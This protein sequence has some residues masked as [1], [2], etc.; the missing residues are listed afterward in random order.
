MPRLMLLNDPPTDNM[1][2]YSDL[3]NATIAAN[4]KNLDVIWFYIPNGCY[5]LEKK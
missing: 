3:Y 5:Y 2:M 4:Q 1:E